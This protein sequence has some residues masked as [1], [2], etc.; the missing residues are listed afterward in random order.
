MS[1]E[2]AAVEGDVDV[3]EQVQGAVEGVVDG[4]L[5]RALLEP[6]PQ[7]VDDLVAFP[8]PRK[9][10]P[11]QLGGVLQV[12]VDE[13]HGVAAGVVEARAERRLVPEVAGQSEDTHPRV[14]GRHRLQDA[15]AAVTAAVVDEEDLARAGQR[16]EHGREPLVEVRQ[17]LFFVFDRHDYRQLQGKLPFGSRAPRRWPRMARRRPERSN[18]C[19][20]V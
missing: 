5:E 14:G 12:G 16:G 13:H 2:V 19:A 18:A 8:P 10:L 7:P 3:G 1:A 15:G 4:A 17:D 9:E 11:D 6:P 20:L